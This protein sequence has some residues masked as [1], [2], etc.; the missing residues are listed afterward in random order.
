MQ[1]RFS[2][3]ESFTFWVVCFKIGLKRWAEERCCVFS[4]YVRQKKNKKVKTYQEYSGSEIYLVTQLTMNNSIVSKT[5]KFHKALW[6][7]TNLGGSEPGPGVVVGVGV[8]RLGLA[9]SSPGICKDDNYLK[10]TTMIYKLEWYDN[11]RHVDISKLTL[12]WQVSF[13]R[14]L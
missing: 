4:F 6:W 8:D 3:K 12:T 13:H 14:A 5:T 7:H 9:I 1:V 2:I 11:T 10:M